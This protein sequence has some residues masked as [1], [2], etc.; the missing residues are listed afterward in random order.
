MDNPGVREALA[1]HE[2]TQNIKEKITKSKPC[3]FLLSLVS[4]KLLAVTIW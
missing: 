3:N 2:R 1:Q 4:V